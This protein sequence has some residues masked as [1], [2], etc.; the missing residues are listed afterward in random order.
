[1]FLKMHNH[2]SNLFK[3]KSSSVGLD[4]DRFRNCA[5]FSR[6][7]I[8]CGSWHGSRTVTAFFGD[9]NCT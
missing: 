9:G 2:L 1:M 6:Q 5:L 8:P 4:I 3:N 7:S